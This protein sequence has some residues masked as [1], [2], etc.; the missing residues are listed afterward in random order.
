[1]NGASESSVMMMVARLHHDA[2]IPL[3]IYLRKFGINSM[4]KLEIN[5]LS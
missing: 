1:M 3:R 4:K 2:R 5:S